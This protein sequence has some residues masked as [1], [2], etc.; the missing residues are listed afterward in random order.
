MSVTVT[1]HVVLPLIQLALFIIVL[2]VRGPG[3]SS[4]LRKRRV[5]PQDALLVNADDISEA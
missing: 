5:T 3:V 4:H 1:L 2:A